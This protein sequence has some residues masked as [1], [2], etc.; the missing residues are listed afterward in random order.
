MPLTQNKRACFAMY[1]RTQDMNN[2]FFTIE[3]KGSE[4][5]L[6]QFDQRTTIKF[7]PVRKWRLFTLKQWG[8]ER[9]KISC[10]ELSPQGK[11]LALG[12]HSKRSAPVFHERSLILVDIMTKQVVYRER[13]QGG[14]WFPWFHWKTPNELVVRHEAGQDHYR[15][16]L[17]ATDW[18][19]RRLPSAARLTSD[20]SLDTE[21]EQWHKE[22]SVQLMKQGYYPSATQGQAGHEGFAPNHIEA[23]GDGNMIAALVGDEQLGCRLV[24]IYPRQGWAAQSLSESRRIW[25]LRFWREWLIVGLWDAE[26]ARRE[27]YAI[28]KSF[29]PSQFW[30]LDHRSFKIYR[31]DDLTKWFEFRAHFVIY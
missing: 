11:W 1:V 21:R 15:G 6:T 10:A 29:D 19:W 27:A 30:D 9:D 14:G 22:I 26:K 4:I 24:I 17:S 3:Q 20:F 7:S 12:V 16:I 25:W 23:S 2:V 28:G 8:L 31:T 18:K 5:W 13:E